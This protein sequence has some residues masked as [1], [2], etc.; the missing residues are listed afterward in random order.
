MKKRGLFGI[1]KG[2]AG[3]SVVPYLLIFLMILLLIP[4]VPAQDMMYRYDAGHSG[5]YSPVA[6]VTGSYVSLLWNKTTVNPGWVLS[7]PVAS[8]GTIFVPDID[9]RL[10]S[11]NAATG[12]QIWNSSIIIS[13]S[14]A[15]ANN[16]VYAGGIYG[17][18][19]ALDAGTGKTIWI[20]STGGTIHSSPTPAGNFLY[21][22]GT[23]EEKNNPPRVTLYTPS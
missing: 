2:Q 23:S 16:I 12:A 14:P 6:G 10:Y 20:H 8:H 5:D 7:I 9:G 4:S 13:S 17:N 1:R 11:L 3:H 21:V 19:Y 15:I 18:V 22:A